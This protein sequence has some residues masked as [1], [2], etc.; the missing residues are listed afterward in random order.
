MLLYPSAP[1]LDTP[2]PWQDPNL[3]PS[4]SPDGSA[5][6]AVKGAT[7]VR[8]QEALEPYV[9]AIDIGPRATT[10]DHINAESIVCGGRPPFGL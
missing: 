4:R 3:P 10:G 9:L 1:V 6:N 2:D 7:D 5:A 8:L